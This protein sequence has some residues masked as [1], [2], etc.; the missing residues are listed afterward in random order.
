M[1]LLEKIEKN[2]QIQFSV[3]RVAFLFE[4]WKKL[5]VWSTVLYTLSSVLYI[6]F[7]L[8]NKVSALEHVRFMQV[9][10]PH[11]GVQVLKPKT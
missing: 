6:V 2:V 7:V 5:S 3:S 9:S 8:L 10:L 4:D 1:L 11:D